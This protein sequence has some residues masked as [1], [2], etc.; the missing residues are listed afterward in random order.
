MDDLAMW[1]CKNLV[2]SSLSFNEFGTLSIFLTH[3][4]DF[5]AE[6]VGTNNDTFSY[7]STKSLMPFYS[8]N[9][10][11]RFKLRDW[12]NKVKDRE[13]SVGKNV[14]MTCIT[15][16]AAMILVSMIW[17]LPLII[18]IDFFPAESAVLV[19][20]NH[21]A[22]HSIPSKTAAIHNDMSR[23]W[24]LRM[25][26]EKGNITLFKKKSSAINI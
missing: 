20:V 5:N 16:L 4:V 26:V 23:M 17:D 7:E 21:Y 2:N 18:T 22:E 6:S 8:N 11:N 25:S 1:Y 14:S 10:L 15:P 24:F 12:S 3:L 9:V 13:E 19:N